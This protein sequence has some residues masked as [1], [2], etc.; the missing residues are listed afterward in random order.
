MMYKIAAILLKLML[1][2]LRT[3]QWL[4][5]HREWLLTG[6]AMLAV[7]LISAGITL[8]FALHVHE[9]TVPELTGKTVTEASQGALSSGVDLVIENRFYSTTVPAGRVLSQSPAPDTV[10]RHG[11]QVR[12]TESLGPQQV[13]IPNVVGETLRDASVDVR[14]DEL[15]LGTLA[16]V[17]A[18]GEVDMVLSQT[19]PPDAGVDQPR[20]N[21]LL[22][23]TPAVSTNAI[24]L[25]S[26]LGLTSAGAIRAAS[27]LGLVVGGVG[28][29]PVVTAQAP[30]E[31]SR[32]V[33]G[34]A[35][36]VSLGGTSV[37]MP[38]AAKIAAPGVTPAT[39]VAKT[40]GAVASTGPV[41]VPA[42]VKPTAN[43]PAKKAVVPPGP[44]SIQI[45]N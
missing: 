26:F 36:R 18:P 5:R 3:A 12:V 34:D 16:R 24:V 28:D 35:V 20:V 1:L 33:R 9:V 43:A 8:R 4:R 39:G 6:M 30:G 44:I 21:L 17:E 11:W 22:S 31:G 13:T 38:V 23:T 25:P 41:K 40:P 15:D 29:G 37:A 7:M 19:P 10:V 42:P 27:E 45:P 2:P 14:R 32:V